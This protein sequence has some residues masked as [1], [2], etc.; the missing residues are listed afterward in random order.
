LIFGKESTGVDRHILAAHLD[1]CYRIPTTDKIRSL[2][3]SN[4]VALVSFEVLRQTGFEGLFDKEP[5]TLKGEDF[6]DQFK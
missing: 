6:L 3:L 5:D 1:T 2:N 4:C